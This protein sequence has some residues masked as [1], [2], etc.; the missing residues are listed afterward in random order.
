MM[1]EL[2]TD[3]EVVRLGGTSVLAH[4]IEPM[5]E[6][7]DV[8][9]LLI[10]T[11]VEQANGKLDIE[12]Y[13]WAGNDAGEALLRNFRR[14]FATSP[15]RY[16]WYDPTSPEPAQRN[17][18]VDALDLSSEEEFAESRVYR[19]VLAPIGL[20]RHRQPRALLCE[21]PSLLAWFGAFHETKLSRDQRRLMRRLM[22][23]VRRRLR[24]ERLL[25]DAPRRA[26]AIEVSLEHLGAPAFLIGA[27]GRMLEASASGRALLERRGREVGR[28]LQDR[29]MGRPP[30][31]PF[32]LI[33]LSAAGSAR[34]W[35]ATLPARTPVARV[36][37]TIGATATRWR[38]TQRQAAVLEKLVT[39]SSTA[40][41]A[42][43]LGISVRA[44]ELHLT[45]MFDRA[46]VES[47]AA[48]VAA[49]LL[50]R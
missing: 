43:A 34:Y 45:A 41:I 42:T 9:T 7:I 3:L 11:P 21:G 23:V 8:E 37:S 39:G 20:H 25:V 15:R 12:R 31:L 26:A 1:R 49:A 32:E 44:V 10:V 48:L 40:A 50:G 27:R 47:R 35:L 19:E 28:A 5:R 36:S 17:R 29:V 14:L 2:E 22:H 6:L 38:L 46:G 18:L 30:T 33:P 4:A 24:V 13:H 16:A